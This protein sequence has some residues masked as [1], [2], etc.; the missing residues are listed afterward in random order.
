MKPN[1]VLH[2]SPLLPLDVSLVGRAVVTYVIGY[3]FC[4]AE[5]W[6]QIKACQHSMVV[7]PFYETAGSLLLAQPGCRCAAGGRPNC[8]CGIRTLTPCPLIER[9]LRDGPG[10]RECVG[11]DKHHIRN[12]DNIS[13]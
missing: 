13:Y 9:P 7:Y 3:G 5:Q 4:Q 6:S 1:R 10:R 8:G 2:D 11:D 12:T